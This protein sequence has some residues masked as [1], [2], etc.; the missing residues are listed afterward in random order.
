MLD[1]DLTRDFGINYADLMADFG[2]ELIHSCSTLGMDR[3]KIAGYL[4]AAL[5]MGSAA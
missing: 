4:T 5:M 3:R 1:A 2:T